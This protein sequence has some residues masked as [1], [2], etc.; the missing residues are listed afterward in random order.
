MPIIIITNNQHNKQLNETKKYSNEVKVYP[1]YQNEI[2]KW[3][4]KYL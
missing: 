2:N 1:P 3:L 4:T